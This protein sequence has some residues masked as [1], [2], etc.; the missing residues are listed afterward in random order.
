MGI[1]DETVKIM[2]KIG[3]RC[4][5][6]VWFHWRNFV[7]VAYDRYGLFAVLSNSVIFRATN[8]TGYEIDL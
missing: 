4:D 6:K 1:S 5:T 3:H 8:I 2:K 7:H